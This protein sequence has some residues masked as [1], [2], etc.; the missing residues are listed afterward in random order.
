PPPPPFL[1]I[2]RDPVHGLKTKPNLAQLIKGRIT[3]LAGVPLPGVH[4]SEKG[5]ANGTISDVNGNYAISVNEGA[6]LVFSF[7]GY[8]AKEAAT[9]GKTE[10]NV[11]LTEET[12][13][14]GEVVVTALGIGKDSRRIG[15]AVATVSGDQ[16]NKARESNVALS[17][18]GTVAGLNVKGTSGG[19]GGTAQILLRG[20]PSMN[21]GGSPLFIINGVPMDNTQRGGAGQWGGSDNGDGIGNINPDDIE[22]MTVLKGQAASALY[23]ARASNGVIL[24]TTK[25]GKRNDFMVEYNTNYMADRAMNNTDFQYEYGQGEGGRRPVTIADA[26]K[27]TR[28]SWG[29]KLDGSQVIQYDG[30]MYPYSAQKDNISKFYRTGST[31][32]NTVSVS[33]GGENG[34]VRLSASSF[35]NNSIVPNSGVKRKTFNLNVNQQITKKLSV[36]AVADYV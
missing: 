10:I 20:L 30:N 1:P 5:T 33:R 9:D 23:G 19:P 29:T 12:K 7:V 6:V 17:L 11:E 13:T 4:V 31:F 24:I 18:Q 21:S 35:D 36:T 16:M 2:E 28:F 34:A 25:T 3:D 14:L 22:T 8:N 32:T 15:Y 27:S 26:Q